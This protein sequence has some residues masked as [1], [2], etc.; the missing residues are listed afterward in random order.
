[1]PSHVFQIENG[2]FGLS[3]TDPGGT[4]DSVDLADFSDFSCQITSGAL[5]ATPNVTTIDV[6]ASWCQPASSTPSVGVTT[7]DVGATILQDPDVMA[8][9]SRFLYEND[10]AVAWFLMGMGAAAGDP[11]KVYGKLRVVAGTIGGEARTALTATLTLPVEGKPAIQFGDAASSI[12]VG[13]KQAVAVSAVVTDAEVA[14]A[15]PG[16]PQV[17]LINT[18]YEGTPKTAWTTGQSATIGSVVV[19]WSS[20]A[21]VAG[22]A[23]FA[24]EDENAA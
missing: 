4:V 22:A 3:L 5:N 15:S 10:T 9:L 11:P 19:H 7:Y 14:A 12:V 8:G 21:F 18:K 16:A 20:T 17:A 1:M 23:T 24:V 13:G 2:Q 6:P